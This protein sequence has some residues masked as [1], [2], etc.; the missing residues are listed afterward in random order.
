MTYTACCFMIAERPRRLLSRKGD[1]A[2]G[3][4]VLKLIQPGTSQTQVEAEA[5]EILAIS[6]E[7]V[8]SGRFWTARLRVPVLLAFFN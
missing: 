4:A 2:G 3:I 6:H 7:S 1:R 5:D 8:E